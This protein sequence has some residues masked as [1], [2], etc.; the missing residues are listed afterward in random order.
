MKD[1]D[2][3]PIKGANVLLMRTKRKSNIF[4]YKYLD[5]ASV[6]SC[7]LNLLLNFVTVS[8]AT[9]ILVVSKA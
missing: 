3:A 8:F 7:A 2:A 9:V 6:S 4:P 5:K 1:C